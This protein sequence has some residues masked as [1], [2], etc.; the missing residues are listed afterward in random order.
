MFI[1]IKLVY[2]LRSLFFF[3]FNLF[4]TRRAYD[5]ASTVE[6]VAPRFSTIDL[7][8]NPHGENALRLVHV[9]SNFQLLRCREGDKYILMLPHQ[10]IL[11]WL[12]KR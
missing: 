5:A 3:P 11:V 1:P 4:I 8:L 10:T 7:G 6:V 12:D 2:N 9:E